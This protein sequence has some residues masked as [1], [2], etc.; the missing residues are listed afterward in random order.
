L[1]PG[2][3]GSKVSRSSRL[4]WTAL[5]KKKN[6]KKQDG[7]EWTNAPLCPYKRN[8]NR[9]PRLLRTALEKKNAKEKD[10]VEWTNAPLCPYKRNG[11][12]NPRLLWTALE[13]E[14]NAK[15]R[16]QHC[17]EWTNAPSVSLQE[18]WQQES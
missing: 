17:V 5:E 2:E 16:D 6:A 4:L 3:K 15:E 14:K 7:V 18:E 12:R 10:G 9:N 8:G 13:R 1:L 11:N